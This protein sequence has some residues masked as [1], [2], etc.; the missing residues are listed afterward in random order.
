LQ[1]AA[2]I[3]RAKAP[4]HLKADIEQFY[5]SDTDV[6]RNR[7]DALLEEMPYNLKV[8]HCQAPEPKNNKPLHPKP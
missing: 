6:D 3:A 4:A 7:S 2:F 5:T 8:K 1:V